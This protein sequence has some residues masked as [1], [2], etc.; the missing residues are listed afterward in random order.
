MKLK[1]GMRDITGQRFSRLVAVKP[2][3]MRNTHLFWY[4]KCDCNPK[5]LVLL[6][7]ACVIHGGTQ[8]CGCLGRE[9]SS[10][11]LKDQTTTHGFA[12]STNPLKKAFYKIWHSMKTRCI[13]E[14]DFG[15]HNY[16]G[17]GIKICKRWLKF[18]NFRDNMWNAYLQHVRLY[19][20]RNTSIERRKV[21]GNYKPSNCYWSTAK[22]QNNNR[23][24]SSHPKNRKLYRYWKRTLD[25]ALY[26]VLFRNNSYSKWDKYFGCSVI[27]LRV[28]IAS[29]FKKGMTW[30]NH[31]KYDGK[32][33][34]VWNID[35]IIPVYKFDLSLD[36]DRYLCFNYS[37]LRPEW[38]KQ[39]LERNMVN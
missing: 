11:R 30:Q 27:E 15:Y 21:N 35:H 1:A 20:R 22:K 37:N 33:N 12:K 23:R 13:K 39:N 26:Y 28:H 8:S 3:F 17:R 2:A 9:R 34:N 24:N 10:I 25:N 29:Q 5:C 14:T 18:E 38:G 36:K 31:G 6:S 32:H 7:G 19:G 16:G 4:F